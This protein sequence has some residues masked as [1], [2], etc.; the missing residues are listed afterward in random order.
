MESPKQSV[1]IASTKSDEEDK[2]LQEEGSYIEER[3]RNVEYLDLQTEKALK[4]IRDQTSKEKTPPTSTSS[5]MPKKSLDS[6]KSIVTE[7]NDLPPG[8]ESFENP[9]FNNEFSD[10]YSEE[11]KDSSSKLKLNYGSTHS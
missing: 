2:S 8:E 3:K 5:S 4:I 9:S 6:L 10:L 7:D 1:N 11:E